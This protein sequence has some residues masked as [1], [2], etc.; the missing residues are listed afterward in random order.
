MA[1]GQE[2]TGASKPARKRTGVRRP[3]KAPVPKPPEPEA[4]IPAAEATVAP[5]PPLSTPA[6]D[7]PLPTAEPP[8][9]A[10]V[11]VRPR[12][13]SR[14][15]TFEQGSTLLRKV[16]LNVVFVV[17]SLLVVPVVLVQFW[18]GDVIIDPIS[19]PEAMAATG[20]TPDVVARRLRD[21]LE[22]AAN[23]G[24]TSKDS[25]TAIPDSE[26]IAF[27]IP[28]TGVSIESLISSTRQFFGAFR[29]RIAGEFVCSDPACTP[30]GMQL[31]LRI[32]Q[33]GSESIELPPIGVTPEREYFTEAAVRLLSSLDPFVAIAVTSQTDPERATSLARR[34]IRSRHPDA[35]WAYNL[36]GNIRV[37]A[38]QPAQAIPELRAAL[39]LDPSFRI[40]RINLAVAL[41]KTGNFAESAQVF[42]ALLAERPEDALV[43]GRR[44]E[45]ALAEG[46]TDEAFALLDRAAAL[47]PNDPYFPSRAGEMAFA[48][49][50]SGKGK[51]LMERA[52]QIDPS[53]GLALSGL[54]NHYL[55]QLDFASAEPIYR[56]LADFEPDD[57]ES[58]AAHGRVLSV[59]GDNAGALRRFEKAAA[60]DPRNA[61]YVAGQADAL[62][63]LD[64]VP[65]AKAK[66]AD[67]IGLEPGR[68]DIYNHLAR[69][70]L[71][72]GDPAGALEHYGK[73]AEF[74]PAD[75]ENPA[76]VA[77]ALYG[78]GRVPE[79]IV[80]L[81]ELTRTA[82]DRINTWFTL[83]AYLDGAGRKSDALA[84]YRKFM[85]LSVTSIIYL[86][87]R[88]LALDSIAKLE[89][90]L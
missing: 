15:L 31:R 50:D 83:G 10:A 14:P 30:A 3:R 9:P 29:T 13:H 24:H 7:R 1:R 16:L 88:R 39:A 63:L 68:A 40:A 81:E 36:I 38:G 67:A 60:L 12:R 64:R 71:M 62:F 49:G 85:E 17:A 87:M 37:V 4:A 52:L 18:Q 43:I 6:A 5:R 45:L 46:K 54:G 27:S 51:A 8:A 76:G 56:N 82:P 61:G 33:R 21:G 11:P 44:A 41:A 84:A 77:D 80:I 57:P 26:R 90:P 59:V 22:D 35:K 78:L 28:E 58:Q 32:I 34:L 89:A 42:D 70:E 55:S 86:P 72:T 66:Y 65:E 47:K 23:E 25:I 79:A 74:D 69:L 19:V 20:L 53:Y 2:D 75:P 48:A 73:A